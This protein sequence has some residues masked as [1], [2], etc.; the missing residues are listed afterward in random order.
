M[1][2]KYLYLEDFNF[3]EMYLFMVIVRLEGLNSG[4][5]FKTKG[6]MKDFKIVTILFKITVG[7]RTINRCG[8]L[9]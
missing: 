1:A 9:N 3:L 8:F 7:N 2:I 4:Y 5:D 6:Q